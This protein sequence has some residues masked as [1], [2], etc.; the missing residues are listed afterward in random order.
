MYLYYSF[1]LLNANQ[2]IL[3]FQQLSN[4]EGNV[5]HHV[6]IYF[7][8]SSIEKW[9]EQGLESVRESVSDTR[10]RFFLCD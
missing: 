10:R 6:S 5:A 4:F 1:F 8:L 3:Y 7:V 9:A 2:N